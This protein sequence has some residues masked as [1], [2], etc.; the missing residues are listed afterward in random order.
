MFTK[1]YT[2]KV[3]NLEQQ[4]AKSIPFDELYCSCLEK[5]N[6]KVAEQLGIL[7]KSWEYQQERI[8]KNTVQQLSES[9]ESSEGIEET[10]RESNIGTPPELTPDTTK[11]IALD[12]Y[13]QESEAFAKKYSLKA[14]S[15]WLPVQLMA[16][17]GK[18]I[19]PVLDDD[20][21]KYLPQATIGRLLGSGDNWLRGA[22]TFV[23]YAK[24]GD[25]IDLQ[26]KDP[27]SYYCALVPFI[28]AAAKKYKNIKYSQWSRVGLSAIVEPQLCEA[29]L[30]SVPEGLNND[31]L[32]KI[33][34]VGM[35]IKSGKNAGGYRNPLTTHMLWGCQAS[36]VGDL[37][38]L[39]QIMLTQIW[40]AHPEA[41]NEYM[42][43][44]PRDWD[45]M[46]E[47][48]ISTDILSKPT[49]ENSPSARPT[50]SLAS[51][52]NAPTATMPWD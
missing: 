12:I 9:L 41:R 46:P 28:L 45:N 49:A 32:L 31:E 40:C 4:N 26:Y 39:A 7:R 52:I 29:M 30:V 51:M 1:R 6:D 23:K 42:V 19:D 21:G 10:V 14:R 17:F 3:I 44:D 22:F 20:S 8:I 25:W 5:Y 27:N 38:W 34:E 43:L 50:R 36:L 13:R 15:S 47:R 33:R 2:A 35:Q 16:I 24:R 37:P 18:H 48:L 11:Q